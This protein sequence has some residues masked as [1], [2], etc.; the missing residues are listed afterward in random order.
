MK[1]LPIL[2]FLFLTFILLN[3]AACQ[4]VPVQVEDNQIDVAEVQTPPIKVGAEQTQKYFSLLSNRRVGMVVNQTSVV[5]ETS[6]VDKLL[7]D[8]FDVQKIF[9]P[10]HG[11]RGT[12]D[13]GALVK[14]GK[15]VKTGLPIISLY[16]K[17]KKPTKS[18]FADLDIVI[19]DIQDVGARFYTYIS[20]LHYVMQTAAEMGIPVLILDRPNPNG[21][22]VDGPV[23]NNEFSSFVGM[24]PVPIVHGMTVGEYG[25]MIN[26]EGW[27][28][29]D[30][31][32]DLKVVSCDNYTHDRPYVLP[33][34]P[35]PN[36]PNNLSIYYYP[37]LCLF[38]G[39]VVSVGRGTNKQFQVLGYPDATI[40]ESTFTPES[41]P[42]ATN[43]RY[44]GE[45]CRGYD[46]SG[47]DPAEVYKNGQVNLRLL[48]SFYQDAKDKDTFF[49]PF[50]KKLAGTDA[51]EKQIAEG[52][53]EPEI[54]QTWAA[55]LEVYK[56]MRVKYLL[57][58]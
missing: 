36:L 47:V 32:C 27:L 24:H 7:E 30:L 5:N 53:T 42:G 20:T 45:L 11:F 58:K 25:R 52:M 8:G 9:A 44:K 19:F 41:M 56:L 17:N 39:T 4:T 6:I 23:L 15:D 51:L 28:G 37:S 29:D 10:E 46:L 13:A 26:G 14:D 1:E 2:K 35:S 48:I 55:D 57:Y 31:V 38:E 22:Y 3:S 43:P 50:F 16:G 49:T 40:G 34:K 54:K 33:I 12:A 18:Q 21:H